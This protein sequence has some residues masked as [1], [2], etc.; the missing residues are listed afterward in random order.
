MLLLLVKFW[1]KKS[2]HSLGGVFMVTIRYDAAAD[3][4]FQV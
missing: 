4:E 2:E 1:E 3:T